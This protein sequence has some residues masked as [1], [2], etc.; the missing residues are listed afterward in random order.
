[1]IEL[2]SKWRWEPRAEGLHV[3]PPDPDL[4]SIVYVERVRPL[5]RIRD[6]LH[7][8]PLPPPRAPLRLARIEPMITDEGEHAAV[9]TLVDDTARVG[10]TVGV[11]FGDDFYSLCV[12]TVC[13]PERGAEMEETIRTCV[14]RDAHMLGVRRRRFVYEPPVEWQGLPTDPF[15]AT[16]Y[17]HDFPA[18]ASMLTV[19]PAVPAPADPGLETLL[20][21]TLIDATDRNIE[22]GAAMRVH[23]VVTPS[24]LSGTWTSIAVRRRDGELQPHDFVVF[25]DT[26]YLYAVLLVSAARRHTENVALL[27]ELVR[28]IEPVPRDRRSEYSNANLFAWSAE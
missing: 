10:R 23:D 22:T 16:W 27:R 12:G 2:L 17:P 8:L 9:A 7:R 15:H 25:R 18:N 21:T 20:L 26:R 11:V 4:G 19:F 5:R 24:G 3:I 13:V 1:M 6:I 28:T 14:A